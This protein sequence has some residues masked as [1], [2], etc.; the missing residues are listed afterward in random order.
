MRRRVRLSDLQRERRAWDA[1][2]HSAEEAAYR[3]WMADQEA[4]DDERDAREA[5]QEVSDDDER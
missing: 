2:E 4:G 3:R 1:F 5:R